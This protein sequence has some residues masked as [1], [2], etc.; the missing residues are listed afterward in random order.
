MLLSIDRILQLISE[1]KNI[2]KIAELAECDISEVVDIIQEARE[3]LLKHEKAFAKRKIILKKKTPARDEKSINEQDNEQDYLKEILRGAELS[4][5]PVNTAI[6]MLV[7]AVSSKD[8][9]D[10]G[11]GIII[12]DQ[13]GRQIGKVSDY[14]GKRTAANAERAAMLRAVKLALYFQANELRIKTD[15]ENIVRQLS[16]GYKSKDS[17]ILRFLSEITPLINK[18]KKF[19]IEYLPKNLN[20]K[21]NFL[22]EKSI[23]RLKVKKI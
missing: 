15:F 10:S 6:T 13:E 20:D 22:A 1:G 8:Q 5:I 3:L 12:L 14:I 16:S 17:E 9:K 4:V 11:I 21:A 18:I 2:E 23:Q 7:G 19:R